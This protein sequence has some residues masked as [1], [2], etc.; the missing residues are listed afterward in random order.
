M[1]RLRLGVIGA[2]GIADRRT[3]PG[4]LLSETARLAAVMNPGE[5]SAAR[6]GAKYGV[7]HYTDAE[8]LARDP[9]VDAVYIAS[10]LAC[11]LTQALAVCEAGK[12][13]LLEKPLGLTCKESLAII[14]AFE[15]A[16]LPL[17]AGLMMRF[18]TR[19]RQMK[20]R[21]AAGEIG[22]LVSAYTRFS[23]WYPELPGAWRQRPETGGGGALLDMGIHVID[24]LAY[25]SGSPVVQVTAMNGNQT[26]SYPV[27]DASCALLKLENGALCSLQSHFNIPDEA[28]DWRLDFFG[29]R[30]CLLGGGV[31]GQTDG[32]TLDV[33]ALH[34][35]G[36]YDSA[37]GGARAARG[38]PEAEFG[39]LYTRQVDSF[40]RSVLD[41][42]P[43]EAPAY[44]ALQAQ[45]VVEAAYRAGKSGE[46]MQL[47]PV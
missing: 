36:G 40:C 14:N 8:A 35:T 4:I 34:E 41:N 30:G 7:K 39:N 17:A 29:T 37:Q 42:T 10:P 47:F 13:L 31:L 23:C 24:L 6:L 2:G 25:I 26:F 38:R 16:R 9:G 3:I 27:E 21:L 18:G 22:S 20:Q 12:P 5:A 15:K 32:G 44:A 11:H 43:L 33:V 1:S 19:V 28:A 45:E 46:T